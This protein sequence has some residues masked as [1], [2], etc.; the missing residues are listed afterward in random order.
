MAARDQQQHIRKIETVGQA[1]GERMRLEM[2][3][4]DERAPQPKRDG[5]AHGDADD[6]PA[7]QAGTGGRGYPVDRLEAEPGFGERLA[8]GRVEQ[9]D[10]GARGDLRHHPAIGRMQIE[11]RAHHARQDLA[12]SVRR[13]A[14]DC[15]RG[16]VAARLDAE[17]G[18][19]MCLSTAVTMALSIIVAAARL[20][21]KPET[22]H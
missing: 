17:H 10:M 14:H 1:G 4:G 18:Q 11:L 21:G 13:Q 5:L 12:P 7:D 22:G 6:Q 9:L 15:R 20:K 8:D 19:R 2:I 16:L 3:D